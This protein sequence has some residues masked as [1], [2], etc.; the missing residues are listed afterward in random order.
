VLSACATLMFVIVRAE[1]TRAPSLE[2]EQ[3][4]HALLCAWLSSEQAQQYSS[5]K[6]F[7]VIGSDTGTRYRIRHGRMVNIDQLDSAGDRV[8]VLCVVPEGNLAASDCMLAQ[9]IALEMFE[10][11]ALAIAN[12]RPS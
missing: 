4:A 5:Q 3:K 1:R 12:Q 8:C 2:A 11:K 9:K 7:E 6:H 10:T